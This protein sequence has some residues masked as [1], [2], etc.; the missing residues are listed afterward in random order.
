MAVSVGT[1]PGSATPA[2]DLYNI[3]AAAL[4]ANAHWSLASDSPQNADGG[5]ANCR[6]WTN[7]NG[8][9]VFFSVDDTNARLRIR[10]AESWNTT[11]HRLRQ[12]A[13]LGGATNAT[14]DTTAV[15]PTASN[16]VTDTDTLIDATNPMI[17]YAEIACGAGGFTY[18]YE[19]RNALITVATRSG[20][21]N[22]YAIAGH[23]TS[24]VQSVS[25][26]HP[27]C[28]FSHTVKKLGSTGSVTSAAHAFGCVSRSPQITTSTAGAFAAEIQAIHFNTFG[29]YNGTS[30]APSG[31]GA[32]TGSKYYN[33][34]LASQAIIHGTAAGKIGPSRAFRGYLLDFIVTVTGSASEPA[35]GDT[36]TVDGVT[37]YFLGLAGDTNGDAS[38]ASADRTW[39]V[40][41][42][43]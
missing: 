2:L 29:G 37:Y 43:G 30:G 42:K 27:L 18:L 4:G 14:I 15:T 35:V 12:P 22:T 16:T 9:T 38:V 8:F 20:G 34:A 36:F 6:V 13:S 5:T 28:L 26:T 23:F 40:A 11:T 31:I 39:V 21:A 17:S 1:N 10:T 7:D 41:I 19:V 25:D 32:A 33:N 3:L 24:L